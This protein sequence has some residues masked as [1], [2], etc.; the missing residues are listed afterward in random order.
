MK[1]ILDI[2]DGN[3]PAAHI[4]MEVDLTPQEFDTLH[5]AAIRINGKAG[6]SVINAYV[7]QI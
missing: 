2:K 3:K 7:H 1:V 6:E 4:C 5:D